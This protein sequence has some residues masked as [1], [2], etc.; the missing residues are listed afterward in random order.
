[1][2][3]AEQLAELL[4]DGATVLLDGSASPSA[5]SGL[6]AALDWCARQGHDAIVVALPGVAGRDAPVDSASWER[7][8]AG[9]GTPVLLGTRAGRTIGPARIAAEVWPLLPLTGAIEALWHS[10]LELAMSIDLDAELPASRDA[11]FPASRDAE[12]PAS[13]DAEL[14]SPEDVEAVEAL[15]GRPP[16]GDFTVVVRS[17]S[18]APVVIRNVPLLRDGTPMPTRYWLVGVREREAVGRL[19]ASGGVDAAEASIGLDAIAEAHARYASERD[20]AIPAGYEGPVPT[21]GVGGTRVGVKCLHAHLAWYLAGGRDPVGRWVAHELAGRIDGPVAAVDC[22]TNSTRLLVLDASGRSLERRTRITRLG[23]GVDATGALAPDAIRRT[24][25][26]LAEYREV[27][28][29][30]GVVACRATATSAA[31]DARNS[32]EL[33]DAAK[34][35]LGT[36]LEL[37][38][39]VEEG[40][41]SYMGA[42]AELDLARGPYLVVDLGGGSTELVVGAGPGSA[43][44]ALPADVVSLDVG[45]VRVT[46]R[47]LRHDPA[48][49]EEVGAAGAFLADLVSGALSAHP[50]LSSAQRMVGV[51]GTVSTL[52]VLALGLDHFDRDAVH[53]SVL[54]RSRVEGLARTLLAETAKERGARGGV[55]PGRAD[56]IA[57]GALVL[58][59]IMAATAH[60]ELVVS[61]TDILDGVAAELLARA[62]ARARA[63]A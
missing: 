23:A 41:L 19:E 6:R 37:L 9:A 35:E 22:G 51:A 1:M 5:A 46:E 62:R 2:T 34:S 4:P 10:R 39:G 14:P 24:L 26:V 49:D 54:T 48:T 27:M 52:A 29:R 55:E 11:E 8:A 58:A 56:V 32:D 38:P 18:G 40:R 33:F 21:G 63:R 47:F 36:P 45:C 30:F 3:A 28:D 7:V 53:H 50:A 43:S 59:G 12:L 44:D 13:R 31:R 17:A 20:T 42:T 15:L 61:E 57:G 16:A 25:A 60:D